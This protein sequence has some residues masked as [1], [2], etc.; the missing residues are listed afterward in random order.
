MSRGSGDAI[1]AF[2]LTK[3]TEPGTAIGLQTRD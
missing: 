3:T 1:F 2:A